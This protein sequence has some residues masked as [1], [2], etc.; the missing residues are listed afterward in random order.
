MR[1]RIVLLSL[2]LLSFT[3]HSEM[4][5]IVNNP[6]SQE[7]ITCPGWMVTFNEL[8]KYDNSVISVKSKGDYNAQVPENSLKSF[9][10]SYSKCR[11][12][13]E[14][15][16]NR[17]ID[18]YP[19]IFNDTHIERM[20]LP[21]FN[22]ESGILSGTNKVNSSSGI[23]YLSLAEVK[24]LNLVNINGQVTDSKIITLDEFIG[25][26]KNKNPG[27]II[28]LYPKNTFA[29]I[30]A[31][32]VLDNAIEKYND[33]SLASRFIIKV[34][35][36]NISQP[37]IL[38]SMLMD[39]NLKNLASLNFNPV[40][41][42]EAF[43][44]LKSTGV[45]APKLAASLWLE[46][47]KLNV[48]A[49]D[50]E[51]KNNNDDSMAKVIQLIKTFKKRIGVYVPVPDYIL[52]RKE[53]VSGFTV[54]HSYGDK[55]PIDVMK[56]FYNEDGSC[57]FV[58]KDKISS[59]E[60]DMRMS[61]EWQKSVGGSIFTS[62]DTDTIDSYFKSQG[63]L[64]LNARPE[65]SSPV[66]AMKSGIS[67]LSGYFVKPSHSSVI[68]QIHKSQLNLKKCLYSKAYNPA[69]FIECDDND[70]HNLGFNDKLLVKMAG[71]NSMYIYDPATNFCLTSTAPSD[72]SPAFW[73]K[74][75]SESRWVRHG[76]N[77]IES[78]VY[79][80]VFI[81]SDNL[82]LNLEMS[83]ALNRWTYPE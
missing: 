68:F 3:T 72:T 2:F 67:W 43:I 75:V 58:L 77:T 50:L 59:G 40:M 78:Y 10:I 83:P 5:V 20:T 8:N 57:C 22:P 21:G 35:M 49:F 15:R 36:V 45:D 16:V 14:I 28:F 81:T 70:A 79:P 7:N 73:G 63:V 47:E 33:K 25:D 19:I 46:E 56:A 11:P 66:Y 44:Y 71:E 55:K 31:V 51:V 27:T 80:G 29:L 42:N 13:I 41:T 6:S 64:N 60:K 24:K 62:Q 48:P 82:K 26:Y 69:Y 54:N 30:A 17:T 76:N 23:E 74:C 37:L 9:E 4:N 52:W 38:L 18:G 39:Q 1:Y 65:P 32:K 61:L 53:M 34:D 12:A